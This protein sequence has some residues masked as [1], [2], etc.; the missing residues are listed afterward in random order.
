MPRSIVTAGQLRKDGPG[1]PGGYPPGFPQ[2][3]TCPIKAYGSSATD[4]ATRRRHEPPAGPRRY[5][6]EF[7]GHAGRLR[8]AWRVSLQRAHGS[9]P[10]SLHRVQLA[11]V[12]LLPRYYE[13]LRPP[14]AHFAALRFLRLAIPRRAPV[15]A[16][17]KPDASLRP[18]VL[19]L[20]T[21]NQIL[22][23]RRRQ[24]LPS[25][26]GTRCAY[27]LFSDPGGTGPPGHTV[28][29][30]GPRELEDEGSPR[31]IASRGSIARPWHWL[32]TLRPPDCSGH[33]ARLA[34]GCRPGSAGWGWLPTGFRKRFQS[35][36][37]CPPFPGF[38]WRNE[39][40]KKIARFANLD[41]DVSL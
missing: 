16:P 39:F 13:V 21:P 12:P 8:S 1:Q 26:W 35:I 18:G 20:V 38:T 19:G 10:P 25:S 30:R 7:R 15:F 40:A 31:V 37:C 33:D 11:A 17:G 9:A 3:R 28:V 29:R 22:S 6:L 5:P 14:I 32:S 23:T 27:A 24:E 34:S 2:I 36:T 41:F 4:Y